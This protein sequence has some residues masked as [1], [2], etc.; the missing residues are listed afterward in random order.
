M[1]TTHRTPLYLYN[2]AMGGNCTT[3]NAAIDPVTKVSRCVSAGKGWPGR[4]FPH[5]CDWGYIV[6][7]ATQAA[8]L[9]YDSD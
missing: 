9:Q 7:Q 3:T 1:M 5:N 4:R 6:A 8:T 2:Q